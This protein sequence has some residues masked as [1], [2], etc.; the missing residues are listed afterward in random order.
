MSNKPNL[1]PPGVYYGVSR[2]EYDADPGFN[3]STLKDFHDAPTPRHFRYWRDHPEE[4]S[5]QAQSRMDIG[6]AV[7]A[8]ILSPD[9]YK[10][11]V[12]IKPEEYPAPTK[13]DPTATN[14]WSGNS[15]WCKQ[16]LA[17]NRKAGAIILDKEEI[18]RVQQILI[19]LQKNDDTRN[20]IN[21]CKKQVMVIANHPRLGLRMKGLL[22][23]APALSTEPEWIFDNK[24]SEL[25]DPVL[26]SK[27]AYDKGYHVQA[28][29][30]M[31]ILQFLGHC[32]VNSFGFIV[33]ESKPPHCVG[34]RYIHIDSEEAKA[35]RALYTSAMERLSV[36]M[37]KN[38]WPDYGGKWQEVK[39]Q[40]WMFRDKVQGEVL[41]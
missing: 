40:P 38:E 28:V 14:K 15:K 33:S 12:K 21:V 29:F 4:P 2:A 9:E 18:E 26:F 16:W 39:F 17:D 27:L 13:A 30:Y 34:I 7:D 10:R 22:D 37:E 36:C 32:S 11:R 19:E 41:A 25:I 20:L 35:G 5:P 23:L 6:N 1:R 3:Q 24:T 8:H 31:D